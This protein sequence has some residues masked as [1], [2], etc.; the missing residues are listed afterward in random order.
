[1]KNPVYQ[2]FFFWRKSWVQGF[3]FFFET[4]FR[5]PGFHLRPNPRYRDFRP[6]KKKIPGTRIYREI[7]SGATRPIKTLSCILIGGTL[8]AYLG[9]REFDVARRR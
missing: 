7:F 9:G 2:D 5:I 4:K 8:M 6:Q 1:M 3:F